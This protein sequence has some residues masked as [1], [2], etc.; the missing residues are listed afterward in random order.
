M[1]QMYFRLVVT[2]LIISHFT[3]TTVT[4]LQAD[5]AKRF[6]SGNEINQNGSRSCKN[7]CYIRYRF[8]HDECQASGLSSYAKGVCVAQCFSVAEWCLHKCRV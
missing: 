8:C 4:S 1:F 7:D 3:T 2:M 6:Q 5:L